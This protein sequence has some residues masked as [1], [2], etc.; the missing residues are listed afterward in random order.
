M[1]KE[2]KRCRNSIIVAKAHTGNTAFEART[3]ADEAHN[4][5]AED[6]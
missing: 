1:R 6:Y 5:A 2:Y 4:T 3:T